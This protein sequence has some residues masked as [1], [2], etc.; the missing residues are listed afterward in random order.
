[1]GKRTEEMAAHDRARV[2]ELLLQ[3]YTSNKQIA[4]II[5]E[6]RDKE[7]QVS[8]HQVAADIRY[9]EG[10]YLEQ[11][12]EDLHATKNQAI[13]ELKY[14]MTVYY[15][16]YE[17]STKN[18]MT[19]ES[20]QNI[21]TDEAYSELMGQQTNFDEATPMTRTGKVKEE[22]RLEGNPAFLNGVKACLDSINKIRN[23]DG[24]NKIALTDPT[25]TQD[26]LGIA[27]MMKAKMDALSNRKE[28]PES[29]RFLDPA[30]VEEEEYEN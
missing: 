8:P 9:M 13:A 27:E 16:A 2:C 7:Y 28:E 14:L 25:G 26:H 18:K 21:D 3:G 23:I 29:V 30:P 20:I 12:L 17:R 15:S 22:S 6:G 4:K 24:V 5:N 11:G 19:V 1:M 10:K